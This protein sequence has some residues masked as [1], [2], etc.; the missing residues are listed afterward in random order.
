MISIYTYNLAMTG[1]P[2]QWAVVALMAI[3]LFAPRL[4]PP[5]ARLAGRLF[6]ME[7]ERKLGVK[8]AP[9]QPSPK[10]RDF[11]VMQP[12]KPAPTY[13]ASDPTPLVTHTPERQGI[14]LVIV[15]AVVCAAVGVLLWILLHSR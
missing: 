5:L 9:K 10:P 4:L 8:V 13:R 12:E 14:P 1:S 6:A 2:V 15:C 3:A 11:E 7:V